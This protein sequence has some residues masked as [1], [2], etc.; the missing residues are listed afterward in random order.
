MT[1]H[2]VYRLSAPLGHVDP[3]GFDLTVMPTLLVQGF[4]RTV[5]ADGVTTLATTNFLNNAF[6]PVGQV[7]PVYSS[8]LAQFQ[9]SGVEAHRLVAYGVTAYQDGPALANQGTLTASQW[10]VAR[11][12]FYTAP[13]G[14]AAMVRFAKFQTTDEANYQTSQ[15]MPN[16]YFGES[17]DGCYLPLRL[18]V[19]CDHWTTSA[20]MEMCAG[21]EANPLT[22]A[23]PNSSG[24][25]HAPYTSLTRGYI[26]GGLLQG[27]AVYAPLNP[28]WGGI[29]VRNLSPQT[30]FAFY[31]RVTVECRVQPTSVLAPQQA[32]SAPYDPVALASYFRISRELKDAYPADFND[33]GKLWEVIKSVAR[34][35]LPALSLVPGPVGVVSS[36][37][38]AGLGALSRGQSTKS[39]PRDSPPAA[40]VQRAAD[41]AAAQR[42]R[43]QRAP[44]SRSK[45]KKR[46]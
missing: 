4:A 42:V 21:A 8:L 30:S 22:L 5:A 26:S 7:T 1:Y 13:D 29:S 6:M 11:K 45:K 17:K 25:A 15:L 12:K 37:A 10:Q 16:A 33:W 23:I 27:D 40:A 24:A 31:Y 39:A 41:V 36:I 18:G 38:N 35:A 14:T 2:N 46:N 3:W 28:L 19:G 9:A 44:I 32:M 20:D 43:L 34:V